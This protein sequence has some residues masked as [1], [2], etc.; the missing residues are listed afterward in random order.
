MLHIFRST[1]TL[2]EEKAALQ[3]P[4]KQT[5]DLDEEYVAL[6][7]KLGLGLGLPTYD[8]QRALTYL[9]FKFKGRDKWVWVPLRAKDMV[10]DFGFNDTDKRTYSK[11][12]PFAVLK[13]IDE[14][15]S[16]HPEAKFFI[17]D[18]RRPTDEKDPFLAVTLDNGRTLHIVERWDEPSFR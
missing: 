17:S 9:D 6:Q 7:T 4:T 18:E 15:Q 1:D 10:S 11:P 16:M 2:L 13:T 8:T 3:P 5:S 12:I 14:I